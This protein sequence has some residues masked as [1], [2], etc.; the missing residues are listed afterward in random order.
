MGR[1]EGWNL[2]DRRRDADTRHVDNVE[3]DIQRDQIWGG[4]I[5]EQESGGGIKIGHRH[6]T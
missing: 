4:F 3:P 2:L 5:Q 6:G 1:V